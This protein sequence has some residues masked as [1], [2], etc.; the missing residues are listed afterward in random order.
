[1]RAPRRVKCAAPEGPGDPEFRDHVRSFQRRRQEA[2]QYPR[3]SG[4]GIPLRGMRPGLGCIT[5]TASASSRA[6]LHVVCDED[7]GNFRLGPCVEHEP[8]GPLSANNRA[9]LRATLTNSNV[10]KS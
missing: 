7:H 2:S 10:L 8:L 1:M 5:T 9:A 4:E 3:S 6:S